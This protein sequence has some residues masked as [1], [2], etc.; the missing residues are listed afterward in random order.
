MLTLKASKRT[1]Q[2][3]PEREREMHAIWV[4]LTVNVNCGSSRRWTDVVHWPEKIDTDRRCIFKKNPNGEIGHQKEEQAREVIFR[5]K[6][7]TKLV[8]Q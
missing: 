8:L 6:P 3:Q 1:T 4:S 7:P 5:K 2:Y